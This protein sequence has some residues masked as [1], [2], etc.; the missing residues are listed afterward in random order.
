MAVVPLPMM[1]PD[2]AVQVIVVLVVPLTVAT[3]IRVDP[4]A[5]VAEAGETETVTCVGGG[6]ATA[7]VTVM[8]A[9]PAA[10]EGSRERA[11]RVYVPGV[12]GAV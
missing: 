7:G 9:F 6:G 3:R 4:F 5:M 10:P 1:V 12:E 11:E 2:V 8:I